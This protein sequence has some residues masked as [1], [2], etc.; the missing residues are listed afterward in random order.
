M[1]IEQLKMV[2]DLMQK[3]GEAGADLFIFY[4]LLETIPSMIGAGLMIGLLYTVAICGY[5]IIMS[6]MALGK[7]ADSVGITSYTLSDRHINKIIEVL[8]QYERDTGK[9]IY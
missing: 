2:L 5:R 1:D 6:N 7:I 9:T 8:K 4:V 3:A